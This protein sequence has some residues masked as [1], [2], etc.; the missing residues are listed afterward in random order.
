MSKFKVR[1]TNDIVLTYDLVNAKV[2]DLWKGKISQ[3]N[4]DD[5]YNLNQFNGYGDADS[6]RT[7]LEKLYE[8]A[9]TINEHSDKKIDI[10]PVTFENHRHALSVM[11]IHFPEMETNPKYQHLHTVLSEYNSTIHW[12]E[13]TMSNTNGPRS[14]MVILNFHDSDKVSYEDIPEEDYRLFT[15]YVNFG[16]LHLG[17]AHIGRHA[18]ELFFSNDLVC[19]KDQF[20]PQ[21]KFT[22][23]TMLYFTD[24]YHVTTEQQRQLHEAWEKFY[25]ERGGQ[26]FWGYEIDDPKIA[27]GALKIGDLSNITIN[28]KNYDVPITQ[29][30]VDRLRNNIVLEQLESWII[31]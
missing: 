23:T 24:Y 25:V 9:S 18:Q 1:F 2:V 13:N 19:P 21:T 5:L 3:F 4:V 11:H 14:L 8:L 16:D 28:G 30:E 20:V 31:E 6:I 7:K 26:E 29:D 22:A 15:P 10:Q 17:Y 12:L 27:F